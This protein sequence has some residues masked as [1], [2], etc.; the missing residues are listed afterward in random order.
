[1]GIHDYASRRCTGH[2]C[3]RL[4]DFN[5][6]AG[7]GGAIKSKCLSIRVAMGGASL[8]DVRIKEANK[9][10]LLLINVLWQH[11]DLNKELWPLAGFAV[12]TGNITQ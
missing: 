5:M 2:R 4:I 1:M 8:T 11:L 7:P 3:Y 12:F 9:N 6:T 10:N